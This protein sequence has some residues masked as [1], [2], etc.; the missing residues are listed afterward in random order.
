ILPESSPLGPSVLIEATPSHTDGSQPSQQ[1]QGQGQAALDF[2]QDSHIGAQGQGQGNDYSSPQSSPAPTQLVPDYSTGD[3][4]QSQPKSYEATQ[5][6]DELMDYE[7]TPTQPVDEGIQD[8]FGMDPYTG[9]GVPFQ[10][11]PSN[12]SSV[13]S[14][15]VGRRNLLAQLDPEKLRR[16]YPNVQVRSASPEQPDLQNASDGQTQPSVEASAANTEKEAEAEELF[17]SILSRKAENEK[18]EASDGQTQ[19]SVEASGKEA[20][21]EELFQYIM[22]RKAENEKEETREPTS[23]PL[24]RPPQDDVDM[25]VV[26]DSE[27]P[28]P[29]ALSP[30]TPI[31]KRM[32]PAMMSS[33]SKRTPRGKGPLQ[34]VV[35]DS[36]GRRM[37]EEEDDEEDIPLAAASLAG[38]RK[39]MDD[40]DLSTANAIPF[41]T[42]AQ[43]R[44]KDKA[45]S[46]RSRATATPRAASPSLGAQARASRIVKPKAGAQSSTPNEVPSSVPQQD[47]HRPSTSSNS[48]APPTTP[49]SSVRDSSNKQR[50]ATGT[51]RQEV[52]EGPLFDSPLSDTD[53][54]DGQQDDPLDIITAVKEEEEE[55]EGE[56]E[57][58]RTEPADDLPM[59]ED[60]EFDDPAPNKQ[61]SRKRKR[62]ASVAQRRLGGR[63]STRASK[64]PSATPVPRPNK[65]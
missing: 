15:V 61:P 1:G 28:R 35:P 50:S 59:A 2:S 24:R 55:E 3:D 7:P 38:K 57:E 58:Q 6:V 60:Q 42:K 14:T 65:R 9:S 20:Q 13:P 45:P 18:I 36:V 56:T 40:G 37:E 47:L 11:G 29:A 46:G 19:P 54:D 49:R 34:D 26:P 22:S 21:G 25:D 10:A 32:K 52:L 30:T 44:S 4:S 53:E 48:V 23:T 8:E 27:P 43:T 33:S 17:Q 51:P 12:Q 41:P 39:A 62:V 16:R 63:P 5:P 31:I 64:T